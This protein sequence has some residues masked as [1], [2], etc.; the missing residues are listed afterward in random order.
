MQVGIGDDGVGDAPVPAIDEPLEVVA[1]AQGEPPLGQTTL[2]IVV[3]G[4]EHPAL[5]AGAAFPTPY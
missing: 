3:V 4:L 1:H 5:G 2:P